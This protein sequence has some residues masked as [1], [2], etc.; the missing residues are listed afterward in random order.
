MA[1]PIERE[2]KKIS[3]PSSSFERTMMWLT[4][5]SFFV[6]LMAKIGRAHV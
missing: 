5:I 4:T 6:I 1:Q 2:S 3:Q